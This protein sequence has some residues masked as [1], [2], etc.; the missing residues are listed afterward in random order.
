MARRGMA[1]PRKKMGYEKP[2]L[3]EVDS[4]LDESELRRA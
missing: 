1:A 2:G 4:L 3:T